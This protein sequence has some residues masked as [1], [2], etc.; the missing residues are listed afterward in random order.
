MNTMKI[1]ITVTQ[2]DINEGRKSVKNCPIARAVKRV[3]PDIE[4]VSCDYIYLHPS[5]VYDLPRQILLP[6]DVKRFIF[7]FD[8]GNPVY[9]LCFTVEAT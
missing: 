3:L 5:R 6:E 9:P 1:N 4:W 2:E 8:F 7:N